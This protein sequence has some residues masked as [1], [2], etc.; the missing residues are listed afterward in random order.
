MF[1]QP[2]DLRQR[3]LADLYNANPSRRESAI[4]MM[5]SVTDPLLHRQ[6]VKVLMS[7]AHDD[8]EFDLR[9]LAQRYVTQMEPIELRQWEAA[10]PVIESNWTC[11]FCGTKHIQKEQCPKCGAPRP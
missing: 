3:V 7:V 9:E 5:S 10:H 6:A 2:F 11:Y 4:H 1:S 8:P